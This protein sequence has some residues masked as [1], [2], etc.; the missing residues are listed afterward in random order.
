VVGTLSTAET[1]YNLDAEGLMGLLS[2]FNITLPEIEILG[3]A[4]RA[5]FSGMRSRMAGAG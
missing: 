4:A 1:Q 2:G 3:Q 5:A